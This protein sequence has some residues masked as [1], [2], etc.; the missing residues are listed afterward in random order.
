MSLFQSSIKGDIRRGLEPVELVGE[1]P[2]LEP[3]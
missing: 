1:S 3:W 2:K